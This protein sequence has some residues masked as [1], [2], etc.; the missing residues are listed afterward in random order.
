MVLFIFLTTCASLIL[1]IANAEE[2]SVALIMV[3][4]LILY[5][6]NWTKDEL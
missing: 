2:A 4:A 5:D 3:I 1:G 6:M